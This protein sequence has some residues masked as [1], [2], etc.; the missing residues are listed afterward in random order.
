[1]FEII[2]NI[3]VTVAFIWLFIKAIGFF[4]K[5]TWGLAKIVAT[6]L[7]VLALPALVLC[8]VFAGG[9]LLLI[10]LA[11]VAGAFALIKFIAD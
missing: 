6:I 8:F 4:F 9:A 2:F 10:P 3:L 7:L 1:M 11:L 5:L